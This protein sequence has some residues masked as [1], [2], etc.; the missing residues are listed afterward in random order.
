MST[1]RIQMITKGRRV[2]F[3]IAPEL[4]S[5]DHPWSGYR[6][7]AANIP[8]KFLPSHSWPKTTL[9]SAI[10]GQASLQWKHRGIWHKNHFRRGIVSIMRRDAEIQ[11]AE[12]SNSFRLMVMQLDHSK[13][14]DIAP[15]HVLAIEKSLGSAQITKDDR[16]TALMSAMFA[17]VTEGCPSGRLYGEAISIALLAYLAGT[18]ATP[19]P[20][21]SCAT[22]LSPTQMRNIVDYIRANL[23]S[24][25]TVTALA[26]LVQMS[27]SH[28]SRVFKASFGV[29]PY[30]FVMQERVEGAE[31]HARKHKAVREPSRDGIWFL[32]PEPLREG[33]PPVRRRHPQAVQDGLLARPLQAAQTMGACRL[34]RPLARAP[35]HRH[36]LQGHIEIFGARAGSC[37]N[38]Q[39][40]CS[41]LPRLPY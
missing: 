19:R 14:Q 12:S 34:R 7:E 13:L 33:L 24:D 38:A 21:E 25:I 1:S 6:F 4:S 9:L 2:P 3:F 29:T 36:P 28:F 10:G 15:D 39:D 41:S 32:E 26:G 20:V 22:S 23:T 8:A 37:P 40:H 5:A 31:G 18:Y 11:S 17:E 30:R 35:L 16:V 27:P